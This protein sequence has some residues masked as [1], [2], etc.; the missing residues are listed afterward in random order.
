[1]EFLRSL[2]RLWRH[3]NFRKLLAVRIATQSADGILQVGMASYVLFSPQQQPDAWSIALV[4]AITLMPFSILGPFISTVLDRWSRRQ[5][6]VWTDSGRAL[7]AVL[8]AALIVGGERTAWTNGIFFGLVLIAMSLN[9]FLLAG[10]TAGLAHTVD[11]EEYLVANSV[12][13]TVGPAGVLVG[14]AVALGMRLLLTPAWET[15]QADALIFVV[16]GLGFVAS[17]LLVLRLARFDLGPTEKATLASVADVARGLRDAFVH[18]ERR[19]PAAL[20]LT[21]L[22]VQ[23]IIYGMVQVGAILLYR[24]YFHPVSDVNAAMA[25]LGVWAG[26]TGAGFVLAGAVT[27]PASA[28]TGL[29]R[30]MLIILI[31]CGVVQIMPGSIFRHATLVA[32]AFV[33]GLGA[34]SLKICVDTLVQAHVD[35]AF[36]GRVFVIYD[37]VFNAALVFAAVLVALLLPPNAASMAHWV[38]IGV[39]F[40]VLAVAFE[41]LSRRIGDAE[42]HHGTESIAD[43][44]EE[45]HQHAHRDSRHS[46]GEA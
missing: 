13:P 34:Q 15:Y 27:P 24:T 36:K 21:V 10:L 37:M 43:L 31:A 38:G 32:A 29:R 2:R 35:D 12:M 41:V 39:A 7:I 25:D 6:V 23:R 1:M 46:P 5:V 45:H 20:G 14:A 40:L 33:L 28:R 16:A 4:L 8:L 44:V 11:E 42:F 30:W 19:A 3:A 17:V 18:L 22:G 9:R 26:L